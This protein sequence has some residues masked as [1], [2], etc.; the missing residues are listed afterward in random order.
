MPSRANRN[1][2][3]VYAE[4]VG[5][6]VDI[7]GLR[8]H[9]IAAGDG[10]PVLFVHGIGQSGYTW[11]YNFMPFSEQ[12]LCVAPDLI[13]YGFS[14][15]PDLTYTIEEN[16]EFLLA[17]LNALRIKQTHIVAMGTGAVYALDFMIHYPDRVGRAAMIAPGGLTSSMPSQLRMMGM[18]GFS[19]VAGATMGRRTIKNLLS[20]CMFDQTFIT[21][22]DVDAYFMTLDSKEAREV[23]KRSIINFDEDDVITK[24]RHLPHEVLFCWGQEDRWRPVADAKIYTAPV[25]NSDLFVL[26]NCGHLMHE[27]KHDQ[28][29]DFVIPFLRGDLPQEEDE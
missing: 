18:G 7:Q 2:S 8:I 12:F 29:N 20:Q 28:F 25:D 11:R 6:Y 4:H 21:E 23:L 14:D 9:Y 13:G 19:R 27:E 26:R 3:F 17:F 10:D 15:K 16:S 1:K 5:E 24:L 22:D